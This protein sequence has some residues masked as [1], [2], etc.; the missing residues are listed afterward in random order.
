[1]PTPGGPVNPAPEKRWLI[2]AAVFTFELTDDE[3]VEKV[4]YLTNERIPFT[5]EQL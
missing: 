3:L 1:M 5:L 2:I 4:N